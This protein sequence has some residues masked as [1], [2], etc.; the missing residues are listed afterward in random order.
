MLGGVR[1]TREYIYIYISIYIYIFVYLIVTV[2]IKVQIRG[3]HQK[4]DTAS[5]ARP[6][7][8]FKF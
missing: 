2:F 7:G 5:K 6:I 3:L 4:I 8:K 1:G